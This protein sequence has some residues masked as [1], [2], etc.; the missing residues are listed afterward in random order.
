MRLLI[1]RPTFS[2]LD[3]MYLYAYVEFL[4]SVVAPDITLAD[5][6]R[7]IEEASGVTAWVN[8]FATTPF[9]HNEV[10][11]AFVRHIIQHAGFSQMP[12]PPAPIPGVIQMICNVGPFNG[13]VNIH[14]YDP[15]TELWRELFMEE[16][17]PFWA[18]AQP[19]FADP[20]LAFM[21]ENLDEE[22]SEITYTLLE[23]G[24]VIASFLLDEGTNNF[25]LWGTDPHGRYLLLSRW[26]IDNAPPEFRLLD[27]AACRQ[28]E[29]LP[30]PVA[31]LMVWSPDGRQTLITN[32]FASPLV[33][34]GDATGQNKKVVGVG[35]RPFWLNDTTYGYLQTDEAGW[36]EWVTAIVGENSPRHLFAANELLA[37]IPEAE[38]PESLFISIPL[39][40][41]NQPDRLYVE[42]S[43][44]SSPVQI[45]YFFAI[46]LT[47]DGFGVQDVTLLFQSNSTSWVDLSPDG[48]WLA[49]YINSSVEGTAV[50]L[51]HLETG[52][53]QQLPFSQ[54]Q[55]G[56]SWSQD[57]KWYIR[58]DDGYLIMGAPDHRY[59][60]FVFHDNGLCEPA[61]WRE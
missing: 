31:G 22:S 16:L 30:Q 18:Y 42:A 57:G 21:V 25:Y 4:E 28:G 24:Q 8:Q 34:L 46:T 32:V 49:I 41:P 3:Q 27:V 17:T 37:A 39:A 48:R 14:E 52:V 45:N 35:E 1:N 29:C 19:V 20:K 50:T 55:S 2:A 61:Y 11:Q 33:W 23:D 26:G 59:Q 44:S 15:Q 10:D 47:P 51:R 40:V 54:T 56:L 13:R 38:R 9:A 53:E 60:Q 12:P 6:Q 5:L 58:A 36:Q 7:H 43:S